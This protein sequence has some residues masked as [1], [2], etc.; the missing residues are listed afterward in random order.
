MEP[1]QLKTEHSDLGI[2]RSWHFL[3]ESDV[4]YSSWF[5]K[6][7]NKHGPDVLTGGVWWNIQMEY[8]G[9]GWLDDSKAQEKI[10]EQSHRCESQLH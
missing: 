1:K 10:L 5:Q 7:E 3:E 6:Q 2:K 8:L 4:I 9:H